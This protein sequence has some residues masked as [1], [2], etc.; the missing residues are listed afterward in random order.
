M[1]RVPR[2]QHT[3]EV[4]YLPLPPQSINLKL[5]RLLPNQ[6]SRIHGSPSQGLYSNNADRL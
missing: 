4:K 2:L 1:S 5:Y 6:H 3:T